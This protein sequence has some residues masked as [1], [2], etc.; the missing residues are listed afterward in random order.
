MAQADIAVIA[1]GPASARFLPAHWRLQ[2]LRG[3]VTWGRCTPD[4]AAAL[5]P[6]PVNGSG[7]LVPHV[8]DADGPFWIMGSTFERDVTE[9][10]ISP[11]D[12]AAAHAHNL[13]KLAQLLPASAAQLAPAFTPGDPACLPTWGRVRLAS[14]DRL[15]IVGPVPNSSGSPGLFTLTALGARGITLST[16]CGE[17]LAAQ[18]HAEPLPLDAQLAQHLHT[19]RLQ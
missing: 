15:P 18:L 1:A 12:Q 17:L 14:H 2:T 8:P 16:L 4:N 6:G 9:M 3:Q 5:P 19:D 7:N 11:A 13:G 10:P